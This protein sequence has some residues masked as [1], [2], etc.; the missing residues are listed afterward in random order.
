MKRYGLLAATSFS[1]L[2]TVWV[3]HCSAW[4][5]RPVRGTGRGAT[6]TNA[7]SGAW[8]YHH[9]GCHHWRDC[10]LHR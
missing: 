4:F 2:L 5:S 8:Q 1:L 10:A 3:L 7:L 9:R 6:E